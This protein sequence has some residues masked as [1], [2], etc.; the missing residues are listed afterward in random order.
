MPYPIENLFRKPV[1]FVPA[2]ASIGACA[3]LWTHSELFMVTPAIGGLASIG[4]LLHAAWR[5][6]QGMEVVRFQRN[7]KRLPLYVMTADDIPASA[8]ELF[9]GMGFRWDQRQIGRAHV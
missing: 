1:E 3:A 4:L 7:L 9:L 5:G 6:R 2:T 8:R